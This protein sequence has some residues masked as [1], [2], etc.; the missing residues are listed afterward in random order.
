MLKG[1]NVM[2]MPNI[3]DRMPKRSF[4]PQVILSKLPF[5][6]L[7]LSELKGIFHVRENSSMEHMLVDALAECERAPSL[8]ES[9]QCVGSVEDMIDFAVSVLGHNVVVRSTKNV[10]GSKQ[11]VM[12]GSVKE[13]NGGEVTNLVSCHQIM[14]P[15]LL[16]YCH[17]LPKVR[18]YQADI[19]DVES[20]AKI[21]HGVAICHLNTADWSPK[22]VAFLA[23]GFSPGQIEVCHWFY[24]NEMAW[25][26]AD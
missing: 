9:K 5:S 8:G 18:V 12:I 15:Y 1:G 7:R 4:L 14:Y 24:E 20:K 25:T 3:K 21:N 11:N 19:L 23:L 22:H 13:I 17:S 10:N 26:T 6:T 16:Y 2:V